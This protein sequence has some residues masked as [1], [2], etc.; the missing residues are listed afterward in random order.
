MNK[1]KLERIQYHWLRFNESANAIATELE[2]SKNIVAEMSEFYAHR[3]YGG[4]KLD[5]SRESV[6]IICEDKKSYQIK[7]RKVGNKIKSTALGIIR[8]WN[9][10]YLTVF[11]YNNDGEILKV[12]EIPSAAA[13]EISKPNKH[14]NGW[15]VTTNFK[16]FNH[17][18]TKDITKPLKDALSI[19]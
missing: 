9:F 5:V 8:S 4:K 11:I 15:I 18:M 10:D 3:Y 13:K 14:R 1:E 2:R 17:E 12:V 7:G 16:F 19:E 6:D